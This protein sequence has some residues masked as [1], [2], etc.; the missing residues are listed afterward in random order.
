MGVLNFAFLHDL[1]QTRSF[2]RSKIGLLGIF[3]WFLFKAS[4]GNFGKA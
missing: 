3:L 2:S 4:F 1:V